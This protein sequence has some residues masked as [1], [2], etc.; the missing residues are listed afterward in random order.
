MAMSA[1]AEYKLQ[2][3]QSLNRSEPTSIGSTKSRGKSVRMTDGTKEEDSVSKFLHLP[4]V[5]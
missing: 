5:R 1:S 2:R 3:K 4:K